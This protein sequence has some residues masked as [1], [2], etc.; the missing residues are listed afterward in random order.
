MPNHC[1]LLLWPERLWRRCY[2][3]EEERLLLSQWPVEAP[4]NWVRRV[5]QNEDER[6]PDSL[7]RNVQRGRPSGKSE[8]QREIANRLGLESAYRPTG[9]PRKAKQ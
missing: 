7:R 6:E 3:T 2:G 8:S 9:P 1:H 5:N 4:T